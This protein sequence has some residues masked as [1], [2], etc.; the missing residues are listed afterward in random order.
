MDPYTVIVGL[1]FIGGGIY[2]L[3]LAI[4]RVQMVAD[5]AEKSREWRKKYGGFMSW[6]GPLMIVYGALRLFGVL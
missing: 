6:A 3:L 2:G 1:I 4:G 5:D